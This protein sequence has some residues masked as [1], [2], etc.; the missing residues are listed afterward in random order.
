[1]VEARDPKGEILKIQWALSR[2]QASYDVQG[3]GAD[4][5]ASFP[6]AILH[7]GQPEVTVTMP[8]SGGVYRLYCVV[9]N[10]R[11]GAAAGSL[12]IKVTGPAS[13]IKPAVARLPLVLLGGDAERKPYVPS[14][15]MGN[16]RR[17]RWTRIAWRIPT[18]ARPV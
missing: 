7:N 9:R 10:G 12:P 8:M 16:L 6:G 5:T 17:S 2:E 15:W 3:L 14:G 18:P 4:A 13:L 1:M 11:G